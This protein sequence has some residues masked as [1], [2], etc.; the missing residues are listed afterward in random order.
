MK[1]T[2]LYLLLI[3]IISCQVKKKVPKDPAT[4]AM[5]TPPGT[6]RINDSLFMDADEA[7]NINYREYL[8]YIRTKHGIESDVFQ[9]ALPDTLIW[10]YHDTCLASL[11]LEYSRAP[12]L[13]DYPVV[14]VSQNQARAYAKWR[15]DRVVE[16]QL[17]EAGIL[18]FH[19]ES[20]YENYFTMERYF[21][22]QYFDHIP[23][24]RIEY[25]HEYGLPTVAEYKL[26]M[27]KFIVEEDEVS[28]DQLPLLGPYNLTCDE[29]YT[30]FEPQDYSMPITM[31][32]LNGNLTEWT[33]TDNL[34]YGHHWLSEDHEQYDGITHLYK[35][36]QI[37]V[38]FRNVARL[39]KVSDLK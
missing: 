25:Y 23:D 17:I 35:T 30:F 36:P 34:T 33:T 24:P 2:L 4:I 18:V 3:F 37:N 16:M 5:E 1:N 31:R 8:Y 9:S 39:V 15:T 7:S 26:T 12:L 11:T 38:G 32:H 27:S 28:Q 20:T 29:K 21:N 6:L 22:G 19:P 13:D 10:A 14:G